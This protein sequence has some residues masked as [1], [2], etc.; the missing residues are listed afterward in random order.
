MSSKYAEYHDEWV[1]LYRN[2]ISMREI[3]RKYKCDYTIVRRYLINI[4]IAKPTTH[5]NYMNLHD[6]WVEMYQL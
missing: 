2:G 1:E 5:G 3:G 6:K 4:G